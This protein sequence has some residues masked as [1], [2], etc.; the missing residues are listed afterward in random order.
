V[1]LHREIMRPPPGM[2]VD[3]I[4][5]DG[6]DNRRANLRV[7]DHAQ[8]HWNVG[9]TSASKIGLKGVWRHNDSKW[10][11]QIRCRGK[12][13]HLGFYDNA[14]EASDAYAKAAAILHREFARFS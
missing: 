13:I 4:N 11:S 14:E 6:L 7:C 12:R 1:Y 10:R 5:G 2:Q 8:N 9:V 3:H